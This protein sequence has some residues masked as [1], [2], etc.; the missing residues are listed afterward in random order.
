MES[1]LRRIFITASS[2]SNAAILQ[3]LEHMSQ[4]DSVQIQIFD[5]ENLS[6]LT[7]S[8]TS[9]EKYQHRSPVLNVDSGEQLG[10]A[11]IQDSEF[12][13][14]KDLPESGPINLSFHE[15]V[16]RNQ[17]LWYSFQKF[18]IQNEIDSVVF[19]TNPQGLNQSILYKV[20][21]ALKLDVLILCQSP[22]SNHFFS[23]CSISDCGNYDKDFQISTEILQSN[24]EIFTKRTQQHIPIDNKESKVSGF[25]KILVFL[26]KIRSL[27]L[28][29]PAY[30]LRHA[31][32]LHEA[33]I[34]IA[35]WKD[36]FANFFY[37]EPTAYFEFFTS[38]HTN[39]IDLTEKFVY[40]PLQSLSELHPEFL[41]NQYG[42]QLLAL[43]QL[44]SMVPN[45]Y[46]IFV[47]GDPKRDSSY[48]TPMFFHRIR[49]I[50]NVVRLPSCVESEQLI[51]KSKFIATVS[52]E[53]G[54]EA[55]SQGKKVLVFGK[56][57]YRKLPG[58]YEYRD[59]LEY[60]EITEPEFNYSEFLR[61]INCLLSQSDTGRLFSNNKSNA[62]DETNVENA[63][64][65]ANT[66]FELLL[67]QK[68]PTFK[69]ESL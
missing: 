42:D 44:A 3:Q 54:W 14:H 34:K 8:E 69:S 26:L 6:G 45:D 21:K 63:K 13:S 65:V 56:P 38:H 35:D 25:F 11:L 36:P 41:D 48:L 33:P 61:Q 27:K 43:E 31:K 37:C 18:L 15:N 39:K 68:K 53:D 67:G 52:S 4:H 24:E 16:H 22:V 47:K 17:M 5:S 57:W 9:N 55:L 62:T 1:T 49:R 32:H 23:Y 64:R 66:I 28:F 19:L 7:E 40:F 30:V 2:N 10:S 58:V 12:R 20:S 29:N 50:P 60:I 59:G 51:E 46:T